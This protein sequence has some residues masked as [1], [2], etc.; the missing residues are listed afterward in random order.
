[1]FSDATNDIL[2]HTRSIEWKSAPVFW[3]TR[4]ILDIVRAITIIAIGYS[5][6]IGKS[7]AGDIVA[8]GLVFMLMDRFFQMILDLYQTLVENQVY[9]SRLWNF[10]DTF[11]DLTRLHE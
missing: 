11:K 7:T 4:Y 3:G 9:V 5:I 2:E 8:F 10:L 6:T 1:M